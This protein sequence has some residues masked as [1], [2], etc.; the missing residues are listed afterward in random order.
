MRE[1]HAARELRPHGLRGVFR[2]HEAAPRGQALVHGEGKVQFRRCSP[3]PRK[4]RPHGAEC[5][6]FARAPVFALPPRPLCGTACTRLGRS[7][8]GWT[9][10]RRA[11]FEAAT[12]AKK[13]IRE[14]Q[15]AAAG[16]PFDPTRFARRHF[17]T[18]EKVVDEL[19]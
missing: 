1:P 17:Y 7:S 16:K 18:H 10:A 6:F 13:E 14:K 19:Q 5:M 9:T 12:E 8:Q 2:G 11:R 3:R 15:F 4:L